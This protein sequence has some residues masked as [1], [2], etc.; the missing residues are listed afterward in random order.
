M[1]CVKFRN[2]RVRVGILD[3]KIPTPNKLGAR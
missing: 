3:Y 1:N 2:V